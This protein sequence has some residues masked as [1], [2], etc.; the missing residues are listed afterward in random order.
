MGDIFEQRDQVDLLLIV[1]AHGSPCLLTH[2]SQHGLKVLFCIIEPI[3]Q[4]DGARIRGG[5]TNA[6]FTAELGVRAGH[7]GRDFLVRRLDKANLVTCP[8]QGAH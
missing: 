7:E 4:V 3:E 8:V 6:H 2:N 1:A 5:H